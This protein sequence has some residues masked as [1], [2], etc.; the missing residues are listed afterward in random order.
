MNTAVT[1]KTSSMIDHSHVRYSDSSN[2]GV[3]NIFNDGCILLA[4]AVVLFYHSAADLQNNLRYTRDT[5]LLIDWLIIND[6]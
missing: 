2:T 6:Y 4:V 5:G 3:T 1:C